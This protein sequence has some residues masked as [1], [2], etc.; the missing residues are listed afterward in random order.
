MTEMESESGMGDPVGGPEAEP[1]VAPAAPGEPGIQKTGDI[2][3]DAAALAAYPYPELRQYALDAGLEPAR[4]K[5]ETI[6]RILAWMY[7]PIRGHVSG[8]VESAPAVSAR[9][10]RIKASQ[11]E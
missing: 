3:A 1:M 8:V 7:P 10:A 11:G 9:I 6:E 5:A 2:E 4:T